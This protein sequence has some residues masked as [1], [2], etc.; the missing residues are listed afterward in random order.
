MGLLDEKRPKT[1]EVKAELLEHDL[2]TEVEQ[3]TRKKQRE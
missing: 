2:E 3:L 1:A